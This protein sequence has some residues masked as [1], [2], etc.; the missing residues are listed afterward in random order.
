MDHFGDRLGSPFELL[1]RVRLALVLFFLVI[2]GGMIGYSMIEGWSLWDSLYMTIITVSTV[3]FREVGRLS[4]VGQAFTLLLII[5]GTGTVLYALLT[6]AEFLFE[7]HLTGVL[8]R[9]R[10][11]KRIRRLSGHYI[12]C[13]YGR[14]GEEA[15]DQ[16][17][18]GGTAPVV[19]ESDPGRVARCREHSV[20]CIE[21]DATSDEVLQAAGVLDAKGLIAALDSDTDN[22]FVTLSS[23]VLNPGLIVVARASQ[24]ESREKLLRAGADKIVSPSSIGGRRMAALLL[25]PAVSDYLDV[26]MHGENLEYQLEEFEVRDGSG[27]ASKT[28]KEADIRRRTG[29]LILAVRKRD[30]VFDTNPSSSALLEAGDRLVVL[31]TRSQL[32]AMQ[33]IV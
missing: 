8:E 25:R 4:P 22:V 17:V 10:L 31:G 19:I 13:G 32:E 27:I 28:I 16:F 23:K 9:R 7:G 6:V 14:V 30:G 11:Q 12:V 29:T 33:Q 5:A 24:E 21:G 1:K 2:V 15:V 18:A 26:I 3:G 20:P